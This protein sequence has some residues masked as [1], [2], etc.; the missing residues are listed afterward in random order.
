MEVMTMDWISS[1]K[2]PSSSSVISSMMVSIDS[3]S[4]MT[5]VCEVRRLRLKEAPAEAEDSP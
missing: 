4:G 2:V 5:A 1:L 3:A